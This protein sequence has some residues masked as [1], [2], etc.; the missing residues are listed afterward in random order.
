MHCRYPEGAGA[1]LIVEL[2]G[3]AAEVERRDRAR[4]ARSVRAGGAAEIRAADDRGRAGRPSGRAA[5]PRSRRSAG[6]A[7]PTS[8]R[9]AWCRG[10]R[11]PTCST[12]SPSCP[13]SPASGW[14]T[15]STPAT[16]TCTRWCSSTTAMPG[17]AERGRGGVRRDP[18]PVHR[19]GRVDHR[20]ARR[21]RRQVAVHDEDVRRRRP[22]HH[23]AAALRVRPG[24]AC[25]TRARCSP[26]RGCAARSPASAAAPHPLAAAGVADSSDGL[27]LGDAGAGELSPVPAALGQACAAVAAAAE[28]TRCAGSGAVLGRRLP[29][30]APREASAVLRAAAGHGPGHPA[31]RHRHQARLGPPAGPLRPGRRHARLDRVIEHAAGDLVARVQAGRAGGSELA[32][33]C[34]AGR[35][36]APRRGRPRPGGRHGGSAPAGHRRRRARDRRGRA[37]GGCATARRGTC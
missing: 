30:H 10:P 24:A 4:S 13:R 31:P 11:C 2:D 20:R 35:R 23:A 9:T 19:A 6:S 12:G 26:R 7:P 32:A 21:R 27:E 36:L 29:G 5:S 1:V 3:P 18:G 37:R 16:A 17:E 28:P 15:S 14:R 33:A 25:A 22:G 8:C 34:S